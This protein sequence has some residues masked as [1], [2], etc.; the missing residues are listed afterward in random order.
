[1]PLLVGDIVA[2]IERKTTKVV[3]RASHFARHLLIYPNSNASF[4]MGMDEREERRAFGNLRMLLALRQE[5]RPIT[6]NGCSVHVVG[7]HFVAFD[8]LDRM[9][10]RRKRFFAEAP[11][12]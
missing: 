12:A 4:W 2:A 8:V 6:V 3:C 1:V 7:R 9:R 10:F 5:Q 11:Q